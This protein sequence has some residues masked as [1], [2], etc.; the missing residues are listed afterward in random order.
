[1]QRG[2][3]CRGCGERFYASVDPKGKAP[4]ECQNCTGSHNPIPQMVADEKAITEVNKP[5]KGKAQT[6][7]PRNPGT[8][9]DA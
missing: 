9:K 1:M 8:P 5:V 4:V 2:I 3:R 7:D 6:V